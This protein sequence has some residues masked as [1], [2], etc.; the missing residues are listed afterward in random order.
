MADPGDAVGPTIASYFEAFSPAPAW[1][2]L[3]AWPPDVFALTNLVL[4]HTEAYRFAVA[5]PAGRRWPPV[6]DWDAGVRAAATEWREAAGDSSSKLP[7]AVLAG[8][9]F[10]ADH[11]TAPLAAIRRGEQPEI[12]ETLLT[13]HAMADQ[14]CHGLAGTGLPVGDGSFEQQAWEL[15]EHHGSL[16]RIDPSRVRITPKTHFASRGITI[17][18]LSR[19]LA[20]SYESIDVHWRRIPPLRG[21][22]VGPR[23]YN[24]LLVP[25]PL[26][27]SA[28]AFHP[29]EGPLENMDGTSFGFF[30]FEPTA[31]LDLDHLARLVDV[32]RREAPRIDAVIIPEGA[33]GADLLDPLERM[34]DEMGVLSIIAGVRGAPGPNGLGRNYVHLGIRSSQG[35]QCYSQEK[36]HR[37]CLDASQIRQYHLS[38][39]LSPRKSWWEA[40]ELPP[41][42]MEIIDI[43]YGA[44]SAPLVCEDLARMDE[45]ADLLRRIGPTLVVALLLDGPQ[46]PQRW[47]CRYATVLADEP[48]SAVL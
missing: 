47:P 46:L 28:S 2:D 30:S 1:K 43:G 36:H 12:W 40:I 4:D 8:W 35:W 48:G 29:V 37:W 3:A 16:S 32:A 14:A 45:V 18:S 5:P 21:P 34:M 26:E 39:A 10:L 25:W 22:D 27:V 7:D 23:E 17:R 44:T 20:L 6:P 33:V 13:M 11:R 24:M 41:R 15:L 9:T 31:P 19:F 42:T 38:R